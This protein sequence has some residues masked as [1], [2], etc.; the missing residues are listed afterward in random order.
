MWPRS[1]PRT[2]WLVA[3][4]GDTVTWNSPG[5]A[6]RAVSEH[7]RLF[8]PHEQQAGSCRNAV[9]MSPAQNEH[10]SSFLGAPVPWLLPSLL[11]L[12]RL[13]DPPTPCQPAAEEAG[14]LG[15]FFPTPAWG[16]NP[17]G[18]LRPGSCTVSS[19]DSRASS[20]RPCA[21]LGLYIQALRTVCVRVCTCVLGGRGVWVWGVLGVSYRDPCPF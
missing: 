21:E 5:V 14:E 18:S 12:R 4:P 10:T 3:G 15:S 1:V 2:D 20:Q 16:A 6:G 17:G 13:G 9:T 7:A 11:L 8:P 19:A